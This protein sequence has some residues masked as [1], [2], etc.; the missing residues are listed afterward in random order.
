MDVKKELSHFC[1][2]INMVSQKPATLCQLEGRQP[3]N[4]CKVY[5]SC[6]MNILADQKLYI[7]KLQKEHTFQEQITTR[8]LVNYL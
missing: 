3:V 1:N 2:N 5:E 7:R 6:K 4:I 8:V